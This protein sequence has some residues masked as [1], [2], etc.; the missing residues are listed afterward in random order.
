MICIDYSQV[1]I[2][3][4]MQQITKVELNEDLL[5]HMVLNSLRAYNQKFSRQYGQ[6]VLCCDNKHY[7]RK[8]YFAGYKFKRKRDRDESGLDWHLIFDVL[9][10]IKNE[11]AE[12][13]PYKV[14]DVPWAEADDVIAILAKEYHSDERILILSGDK[15]FQ[16]LQHFPNIS[17]FS[18]GLKKFIICEEP[19]LFL[20]EHIIRGDSGDSIPNYLSP[21]DVF[22]TGA[23]QKPI[24]KSKLDEWLKL[25][26]EQFCDEVTIQNFRRNEKLVDLS[27]IPA[28]LEQ[29]ILAEFDKP[30][31]G[32]KSKI[33]PYFVEHRMKNLLTVVQEF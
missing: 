22:Q 32:D 23:R 9:Q 7:W 12:T 30:A 5:R 8:S 11:I 17:Q 21:D 29:A 19:E 1:S 31:K 3:N 14:I 16:Q 10:K 26:P 4:L 25:P 2:S 13:F 20:K 33:L 24:M 28:E 18:P 27:Q 15:D 6:M